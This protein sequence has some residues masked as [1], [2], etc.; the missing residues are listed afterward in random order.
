MIVTVGAINREDN[1]IYRPSEKT[2]GE[3]PIDLIRATRPI[4]IVDEPQ[5][6]D[7]GLKGAGK[8]ALDAM[9]AL[10]TL[11]YSATHVDKHHMVFRLD[12]VDA[13]E[14][15]LV[16]QIEVAAATIEE[17]HNRPYVRL[18]KTKKSP[19]SA[20]VEI[21]V[22]GASGVKRTKKWVH[23]GDDLEQ[24]T[25]RA[26]YAGFRV[27]EI[28]S[29]KND[30]SVEV[31]F[32]G[33]Q[34]YLQ[35]G[36]A[37]G[38]V[39][40]L[41]VQ[42]EMIRRTIRE[43]LD[44]ELRL[45]S[46]GIKVLSLFFIDKVDRYRQYDES[47]E[48]VKGDYA[49][50][51][52]EEYTR[53]AQHP[54]YST[55]FEG[56][57]L[58]SEASAVHGGY[59]SIDKKSE[60]AVD[61]KESNKEGQ[62]A[63][64]RA[65][66]LIMK[67]KEKLLALETPLKFI[68]SHSALRE[69]WDNPNVFQIC[70]LRDVQSELE[71]RQTIGRGLRLCV[72]QAGERVRDAS[73]N[74]LTVVATESYEEFAAGLQ[75]E[76]EAE[77]GIR[78]GVIESDA[79]AGI[80]IEQPGGV[81]ASLGH[82]RSEELWT[83]LKEADYLDVKG[84]IQDSLRVALQEENVSI[85]DSFMEQHDE[86]IAILRRRAGRLE[87]KNAAER[88]NV[89]PRQVILES[90]QF[91]ELWDRVKHRTTYR[92]DFDNKKLVKDCADALRSGPPLPKTR[93]MWRKAGIAIGE[94]GVEA[95]E[96]EASGPVI[97]QETGIQLPDILTELQDKTQLTRRSLSRILIDSDRLGDFRVN[98]QAFAEIAAEVINRCKRLM[99]VDGIKYHRIGDN[100][101]YAQE[102]FEA[103]EI[104]GYLKNM[105]LDPKKSL[106]EHVVYDF[107]VEARFAEDLEK[108]EDVKVYAKLPGWFKIPTPLGSYNPDWAV[109]VEKDGLERLYFVVETKSTLFGD[110]RR[111]KENA[112][113]RC[114]AA[115][116]S[117]LAAGEDAAKYIV[118]SSVDEMLSHHNG[119]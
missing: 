85:P 82:A 19:I 24:T 87:V 29:A 38:E 91:R 89:R 107:G 22:E 63:A 59:F 42:R 25:G 20:Q 56:V 57:D 41:L 11:R 33:G 94:A 3:K 106:Y 117:A 108:N 14:R 98:P 37:Y 49:A 78:F 16:K 6:V 28:R 79:F 21:D 43:H 8:K 92:V 39:E 105:I 15:R 112:K 77:T 55:L 61:T 68:F 69:G 70:T 73:I 12:A 81:I 4:V 97:L 72:N 115:H 65:Y 50:I 32:D 119:T 27:G 67:E 44:K 75:K 47:G 114:G 2:G 31:R 88:K 58:T 99:I 101:F 36:E 10:C 90:T 26:I 62:E 17:A 45:R 7:G 66:E 46:Q 83:H 100:E 74:T 118:S 53:L 95:A 23:D 111:S 52:E 103:S 9:E 71:R 113:I 13:Y 1:N 34:V 109:L 5:S 80:R 64:L 84:E 93:L 102:L 104:T 48:P 18:V 96:T 40:G 51:F 35:K 60:R 76:I 116:F 86:I 30:E 110:D 54:R